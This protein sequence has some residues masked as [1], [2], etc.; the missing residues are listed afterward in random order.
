VDELF[1]EW[2]KQLSEQKTAFVGQAEQI[3]GWDADLRSHHRALLSLASET[4]EL[5]SEESKLDSRLSAIGAHLDDIDSCIDGLREDTG[6]L[7]QRSSLSAGHNS[8]DMAR[9]QYYRLADAVAAQLSDAESKLD[10]LSRSIGGL[11][12]ADASSGSM[13]VVQRTVEA[14][15]RTMQWVNST[16]EALEAEA[17]AVGVQLQQ[18]GLR[19]SD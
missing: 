17:N 14:H 9:S 2:Q 15:M 19:P 4:H 8:A 18:V 6:V 12:A 13:E 16:V 11:A 3:S 5:K 10:S 1:R 7:M